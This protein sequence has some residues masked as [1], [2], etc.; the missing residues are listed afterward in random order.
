MSEFSE[1]EI[2]DILVV[3]G[4]LY[5]RLNNLKDTYTTSRKMLDKPLIKVTQRKTLSS[6]FL[7]FQISQG[8][9]D[10]ERLY[11]PKELNKRIAE[12]L[13]RESRTAT[14]D[15]ISLF[16]QH[17]HE[18]FISSKEFR[19]L[20]RL[21]EKLK[22]LNHISGKQTIKKFKNVTPEIAG[23]P[24]FYKLSDNVTRL[25]NLLSKR[26][27]IDMIIKTLEKSGLLSNFLKKVFMTSILMFRDWDEDYIHMLLKSINSQ[28]VPDLETFTKSMRPKK[29]ILLSADYDK[30]ELVS[31][32]IVDQMVSEILTTDNFI[33]RTIILLSLAEL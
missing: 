30:I 11:S 31:Q 7:L 17:Q 13:I 16:D 12:N 33:I 2:G 15:M 18:K 9:L 26:G 32:P 3:V 10:Q 24:E 19:E 29:E 22:L 1:E 25:G 4:R 14:D 6:L 23:R 20:L 21:F 27:I 8:K 5:V 28:E